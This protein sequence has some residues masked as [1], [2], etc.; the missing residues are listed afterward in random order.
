[1]HCKDAFVVLSDSGT[2]SEESSILKFLV[3]LF[4]LPQKTGS[5]IKVV[6]GGITYNNLIQSVELARDA[7]Q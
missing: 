7:K 1:M 4:E 5:K 2:L 6:I 3:S